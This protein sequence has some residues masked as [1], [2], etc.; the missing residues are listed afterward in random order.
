MIIEQ[1]EWNIFHFVIWKFD[2]LKYISMKSM[3]MR[4][5]FMT[6]K[7]K[8]YDEE[9]NLV[10]DKKSGQPVYVKVERVVRHNAYY[11]PRK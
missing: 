8:K 9:G 6:F 10:L 7:E 5:M 1:K 11:I 2:N 3:K 4:S